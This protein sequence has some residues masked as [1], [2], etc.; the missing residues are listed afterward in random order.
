MDLA[1]KVTVGRTGQVKGV[2]L[3]ESPAKALAYQAP[4]TFTLLILDI[5]FWNITFP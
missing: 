5:V 1:H 4:F 3:G 2:Y